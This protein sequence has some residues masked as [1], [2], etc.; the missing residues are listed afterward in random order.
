MYSRCAPGIA[1]GR[2][3]VECTCEKKKTKLGYVEASLM[4]KLLIDAAVLAQLHYT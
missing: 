3:A 1:L 2:I 4:E